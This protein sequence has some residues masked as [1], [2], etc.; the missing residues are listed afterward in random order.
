MK[1]RS[2]Q[3]KLQTAGNTVT[4]PANSICLSH[5]CPFGY[6]ACDKVESIGTF[7]LL[8]MTVQAQLCAALHASSVLISSLTTVWK[9]SE[10]KY[11]I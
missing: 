1:Q 6:N 7:N 11:Y 8:Y 10:E 4:E 9:L 3:F 5:C 2:A